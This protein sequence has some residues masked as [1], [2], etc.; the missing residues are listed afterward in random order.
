VARSRLP[1]PSRRRFLLSLATTGCVSLAALPLR[2]ALAQ[3][4]SSLPHLSEDDPLAKSLGYKSDAATVDKAKA[5][6]FKPG[7]G[8]AMCRFYQGTPTDAFG[9]CQVFAG[10]AVSTKGWCIS[11]SAKT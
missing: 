8:C 11:F 6:T 1:Y 5:P 9:P 10:K 4:G 3:S 2:R 7:Q